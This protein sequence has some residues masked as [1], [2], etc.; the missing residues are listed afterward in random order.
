MEMNNMASKL[1][2]AGMFAGIGGIE[3]GLE[4]AG[5]ETTYLCEIDEKAR[6]VLSQ[7]FPNIPCHDDIATLESLPNI[8]VLSAGFPCQNISQ[9]GLKEGIEGKESGL[10]KHIFRLLQQKEPIDRPEWIFF[11]NVSYIISLHGGYA[12]NYLTENLEKLGYSWAYRIIDARA[13]GIPQRRLRMVMIAAKT[14]DPRDV[15]FSSNIPE[16]LIDD[17]MMNI[18][19]TLAYGFYWTEGERGIGWTKDGVPTLKIGSKIGIPSPPA[20]WFPSTDTFGT[21]DIRDAEKL[22]GFPED[23]TAICDTVPNARR[24]DRWKQVGNAVC[25]EMSYWVGKR[26]LEANQYKGDCGKQTKAKKWPIACWGAK[27]KRYVMQVSTWPVDTPRIHLSDFLKYPVKP[28]SIKASKGFYLRAKRS[29]L[30]NYSEQFLNSL[31]EYI[32]CIGGTC[33]D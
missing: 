14:G 33:D 9:A 26:I 32:E 15:L 23:W 22:Q 7:H 10:V 18:D 5:M 12:M 24:G 31:K 29:K 13:F 20:I 8:D 27:G 28:L 6:M 16:P 1:K 25:T 21:P 19:S 4:R 3:V 30:I 11:E 17:D 2:V